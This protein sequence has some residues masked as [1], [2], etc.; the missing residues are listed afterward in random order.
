M[1]DSKVN[2]IVEKVF[3]RAKES[4]V[5]D[6]K[7]ALCNQVAESCNL[8]YKTLERL[9]GR[10]I[11]NKEDKSEPSDNTIDELC[12]YLG[13]LSYADYLGKTKMGQ[14][15]RIGGGTWKRLIGTSLLLIVVVLI[16]FQFFDLRC[17]SWTGSEYVKVACSSSQ[18]NEVVPLDKFQFERMKKVEVNAATP[19]FNEETKEPLIWYHKVDE[20]TIEYFTDAGKHP[21]NGETLKAITPYIIEKYVPKHKYKPSSF[22]Q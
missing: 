10:Y 19:F 13:Y 2:E 4:T 14:V 18:Q 21:V 11:E 1:K 15:L 8:S 22:I 20:N 5:N 7:N 9:Y 16:Y 12:R 6:S 17:M 3:E